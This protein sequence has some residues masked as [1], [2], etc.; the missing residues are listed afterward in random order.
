MSSLCGFLCD[1]NVVPFFLI[2]LSFGASGGLCFANVAFPGYPF[3]IF[4]VKILERCL[5]K[6]IF[7][8]NL[9]RLSL[10]TKR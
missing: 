1:V 10:V 8:I 5:A 3:F 4:L 7:L 6:L 2:P 9:K